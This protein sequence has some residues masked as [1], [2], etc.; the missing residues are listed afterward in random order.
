MEGAAGPSAAIALA[1]QLA[2][3]N[4][5]DQDGDNQAAVS[6]CGP[7]LPRDGCGEV[8]I[9]SAAL[10]ASVGRV[11]GELYFAVC[12]HGA[13]D[14]AIESAGDAEIYIGSLRPNMPTTGGGHGL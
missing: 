3:D 8:G 1:V 4:R 7:G 14:A 5:V 9:F 2:L 11:D 12:G 6:S 13:F 10:P